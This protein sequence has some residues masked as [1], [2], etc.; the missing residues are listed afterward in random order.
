VTINHI[1]LVVADLERTLAFYVRVLGM[2]VTFEV[3]LEGEW[4]ET[5][6]GIPGARARCAFVMPS[7]GGCRIEL[8]QYITPK[9]DAVLKNSLANTLGLRHF[10]LDVDDLEAWHAKL[11]AAGVTPI[12]A[13]VTVPFRLVDGVQKRL[14]YCHDPDGVIVEFCDYEPV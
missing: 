9:G 5:V 3:D 13:P 1:N 11:T 12:S 10:A 6:V 4:I 7:K 14:F 8:L 2:R